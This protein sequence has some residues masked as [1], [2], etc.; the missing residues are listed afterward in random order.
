MLSRNF[1]Q[2]LIHDPNKLGHS[3]IPDYLDSL[4]GVSCQKLPQVPM[5]VIAA[6]IIEI[7][8]VKIFKELRVSE[9]PKA[10]SQ[11]SDVFS[12]PSFY[13]DEESIE[14]K[15]KKMVM[16]VQSQEQKFISL[17]RKPDQLT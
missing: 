16:P 1:M 7:R 4:A 12:L 3:N 15:M 13:L 9:S 2:R 11:T 17:R 5:T 6:D 14:Q 8:A 10:S